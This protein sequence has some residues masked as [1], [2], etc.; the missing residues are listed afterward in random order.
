[1]QGHRGLWLLAALAVAGCGGDDDTRSD[2]GAS[3]GG[4]ADAAG[5]DGG[6]E[7]DAGIPSSVRIVAS[8]GGQVAS[9]DGVFTLFVPPGAIAEDTDFSVRVL[10][11]SE[12]PAAFDDITVVGEVYDVQPDGLVFSSPARAELRW[13]SPPAAVA[14]LGTVPIAGAT[15]DA[16]G[17][18]E[19]SQAT[20]VAYRGDGSIVLSMSVDHLSPK[21]AHLPAVQEMDPRMQQM[22]IDAEGG[23]RSV[24]TPFGP[25]LYRLEAYA[26]WRPELRNPRAQPLA[27]A[28]LGRVETSF[29]D[30]TLPYEPEVETGDLIPMGATMPASPLMYGANDLPL[31]SWTCASSGP[32]TIWAGVR[33]IFDNDRSG[34][35]LPGPPAEISFDVTVEIDDVDC[36]GDTPAG[37]PPGA[38][39]LLADFCEASRVGSTF[40]C[41]S[42]ASGTIANVLVPTVE[43]RSH[44]TPVGS[45]SAIFE[46]VESWTSE[47]GA[48]VITMTTSRQSVTATH[49]GASYAVSGLT[50]GPVLAFPDDLVVTGTPPGGSEVSV[51]VPA[52]D[53]ATTYL[54][55]MVLETAEGLR[56]RMRAQDGGFDAM[57]VFATAT[58]SSMAGEAGVMRVVPAAAMTVDG[59]GERSAPL[60]D[61]ATITALEGR[62]LT[63]DTIL[64]GPVRFVESDAL[65]PGETVPVMAGRLLRVPASQLVAT[66]PAGE[67]VPPSADL[68]RSSTTRVSLCYAP[69]D[70]VCGMQLRED[71]V[72]AE[73][74]G[75]FRDRGTDF[76][77]YTENDPP[78]TLRSTTH[79]TI[80]SSGILYN[81]VVGLPLDTDITIQLAAPVAAGSDDVRFT[82]RR[83][84]TVVE[85]LDFQRVPPP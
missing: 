53:P 57:Y 17:A 28:L 25:T 63:L 50:T 2:A 79:G 29:G 73:W 48:P 69:T 16:E 47:A 35:P 82:F 43:T 85:V 26:G 52:I 75:S 8:E 3:D 30:A 36:V 81:R 78:L 27:G 71:C 41:S 77:F 64:V 72:L 45:T 39:I 61:D 13:A 37:H 67:C 84:G 38:E 74:I 49:D 20:L 5:R 59:T 9:P 22:V 42:A 33:L 58:G 7:S 11:R 76:T 66:P 32:D 4:I 1:M 40:E 12:W 6:G 80:E 23:T 60:L 10:P 18:L 14:S 70:M 24:G 46:G 51:T 65:F 34:T 62:G 21:L 15:L 54:T 44:L 19:Y 68:A 56:S 83:T 55:G 31:F